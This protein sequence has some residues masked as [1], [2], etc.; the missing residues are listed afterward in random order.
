M[1]ARNLDQ[2]RVTY[3]IRGCKALADAIFATGKTHG[4]MTEQQQIKAIIWSRDG[5]KNLGA[6][7]W[8]R[9]AVSND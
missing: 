6:V 2:M 7:G 5:M 3:Q 9:Q 1:R 4:P 8:M